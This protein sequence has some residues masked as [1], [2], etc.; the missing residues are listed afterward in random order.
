MI[1]FCKNEKI[2]N[3]FMSQIIY[4]AIRIVILYRE[5]VN[6]IVYLLYFIGKADTICCIG[7]V[8]CGKLKLLILMIC[9]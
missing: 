1:Y 2:V 3:C 4:C 5:I 7:G 9:V 6:C 8:L